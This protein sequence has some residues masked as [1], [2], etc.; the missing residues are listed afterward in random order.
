MLICGQFCAPGAPAG[1][2]QEIIIWLHRETAAILRSPNIRERLATEGLEV[3]AN[4]PD[5]FAALVRAD[6]AKWTRL[7]K[8]IG[9]SLL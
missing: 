7:V 3:V 2:A 8:T 4:S 5:A 9:M 6:I 1:T